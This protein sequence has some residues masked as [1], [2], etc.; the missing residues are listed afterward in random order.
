M[1]STL[2]T[3]SPKFRAAATAAAAC[4]F[5]DDG[6]PEIYVANDVSDNAM[7]RNRGHGRFQDVSHSAWVADYRGAMG[8]G[9]GDWDGDLDFDIFVTHWISEENTLYVKE[10]GDFLFRDAAEETSLGP[11]SRMQIGWACDFA[12]FDCDGRPDIAYYGEPKELVVQYN[13]GTNGWSAPKRWPLE[14]SQLTPNGLS[15]GDLNGDERPDLILL[16]INM[17]GMNGQQVTHLVTAEHLP[18]RIV[19]LTG[20]DDVEQAIHAAEPR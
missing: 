19:L 7:F 1:I 16:D 18:T 17:P 12:D 4:D 6:Y 8:L 13:Q 20:Y 14:D 2:T 11:P 9:I 15:T 3:V 5:D 10:E